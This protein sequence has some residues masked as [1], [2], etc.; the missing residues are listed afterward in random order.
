MTEGLRLKTLTEL[1]GMETTTLDKLL[2]IIHNQFDIRL[3]TYF[4]SKL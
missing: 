2:I 4:F 1:I 3:M